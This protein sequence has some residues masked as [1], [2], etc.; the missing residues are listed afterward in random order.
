M[1][2]VTHFKVSSGTYG[3][4]TIFGFDLFHD[5]P[6]GKLKYQSGEIEYQLTIKGFTD[7]ANSKIIERPISTVF[8]NYT[9][10]DKMDL[11]KIVP[12][13]RLNSSGESLGQQNDFDPVFSQSIQTDAVNTTIKI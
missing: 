6:I 10:T 4:F 2:T 13:E 1:A 8:D 12:I 3:A 11:V 7:K 9:T 5:I